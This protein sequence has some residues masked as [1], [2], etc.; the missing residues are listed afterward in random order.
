[1]L[2]YVLHLNESFTLIINNIWSIVVNEK[3]LKIIRL[4]RNLI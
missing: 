4:K 2:R 3:K 1:M